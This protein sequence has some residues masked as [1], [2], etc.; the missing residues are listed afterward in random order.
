MRMVCAYL[1][2]LG[3]FCVSPAASAGTYAVDPVH[4]AALFTVEHMG[5]SL[6]HGRFNDINGEIV[7]DEED[8][9]N[10]AV[11]ITIR[12]ESIDTANADRDDRLRGADFMNTE[13][14]PEMTFRSKRFE[15][16]E[17][18]RFLVTGDF[19]LLGT[20]EE[21][22]VEVLKTG[23]GEDREGNP[24]IGFT[25]TFTIKRSEFGMTTYLGPI[26]D[27]V[28]ITISV[29]AGLK[30]DVVARADPAGR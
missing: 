21:L 20:T 4:S 10:N 11:N 26:G 6:S 28:K 19:T 14:F 12:T 9:T 18:N 17:G 15:A 23:E 7:A 24:L 25:T 3:A 29:E 2:C 13:E 1:A 30:K 5:V 22:N 16:V 27:D 8:S